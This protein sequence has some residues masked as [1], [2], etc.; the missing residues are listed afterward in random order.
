[1]VKRHAPCPSI[2]V[3]RQPSSAP[4]ELHQML[5]RVQHRVALQP[6][7]HSPVRCCFARLKTVE[8]GAGTLADHLGLAGTWKCW[9]RHDYRAGIGFG[10]CKRRIPG[11]LAYEACPH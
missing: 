2:A 10:L 8:D 1:M 3:I 7:S 4:R 6:S 11:I 9:G 5:A